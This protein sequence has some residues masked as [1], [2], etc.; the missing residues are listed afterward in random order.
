MGSLSVD[1]IKNSRTVSVIVPVY[2]TEEYLEEC[3]RSVVNQDY[4]DLEIVLI[5]DGSTDG[6]GRICRKWEALDSRIRYVEKENEGQGTTRNQGIRMASGKYVIFVDSDDYIE[7]NLVSQ[8]YS[9]IT[10]EKADI[11]VYASCGT[12]NGENSNGKNGGSLE[13]KLAEGN[14]AKE[15]KE[16]LGQLTPILCNKMF[17]MALLRKTGL[18]M[19]NRMCEDLVF[20][21]RIYMEAKKI[22]FLDRPLY[23]YRYL[24]EGNF[25]T[26]YERYY[27]VEESI[28]ELIEIFRREGYF[29]EYWQQ[30]YEISFNMFKTVLFRIGV[31]K[32]YHVPRE[33]KEKYPIFFHSYKNALSRWFQGYLTME[34]QEKNFLLVGSYSLRVMI[35]ALLLNE[36]YLREDYASSSIVS[37]MS[38]SCHKIDNSG[39][40]ND[41]SSVGSG[42][43]ISAC[44]GTIA[45]RLNVLLENKAWKN[46]YRKRC[47]EQDIRKEFQSCGRLAEADYVAVD[48]LDEISDLIEIEEGC[49]ITDS[50]FLREAG[51]E[52]S[53]VLNDCA[54][55]SFVS[56]ARRELFQ[57]YAPIFAQRLKQ[58][59]IPVIIVKNF[60]CEK[61]GEYYDQLTEYGSGECG[62]GKS[63]SLEEIREINRELEWCYEYLLQCLP[64]AIVADASDFRELEFTHDRFPFGR[65]PIYY[66]SGYYQ[67][68][69]IHVNQAIRGVLEKR[70]LSKLKSDLEGYDRVYLIREDE[71]SGEKLLED[72]LGSRALRESKRKVLVMAVAPQERIREKSGRN[73]PASAIIGVENGMEGRVECRRITEENARFLLSLYHM[74]EFS[75]RFRLIS[76][77]ER[78][79]SLFQF[80]ETG[81][82]SMEEVWE[83]L[84]S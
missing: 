34:L 83:A 24:R 68:M 48:L 29:E 49:Y 14:N 32:E 38:H 23:H 4:S 16:L 59:G 64:E 37:L 5:N 45:D 76:T 11:C 36:E 2:N 63:Y 52:A 41:G 6:S 31:W 42:R 84:L 7:R 43:D 69:A 58:T 47:V 30:L 70:W 15:N 67:R 71:A 57:R 77:R 51:M 28:R 73:M 53:G 66:N 25:S 17:S 10:E 20:N 55:I 61:Q 26:N 62:S 21:A 80:S 3:I 54:R 74:Y 81:L 78:C 60:L 1:R 79:G 50:E 40:K 82:L 65:E 9:R 18:L 56:P 72:F 8:V 22:C 27:Q 44:A 13:F 35:H 39:Q 46:P 33:I 75:D 19:N 12:E